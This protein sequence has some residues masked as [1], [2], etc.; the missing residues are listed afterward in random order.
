M[1]GPVQGSDGPVAPTS[2][3]TAVQDAI[4]V[5]PALPSFSPDLLAAA[6]AD[7]VP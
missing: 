2:G 6:G 1:V 7:E 3:G 5:R 4:E